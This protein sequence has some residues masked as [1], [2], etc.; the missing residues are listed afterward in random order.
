MHVLF[1]GHGFTEQKFTGCWRESLERGKREKE[2]R[3]EKER[4]RKREKKDKPGTEMKECFQFSQ[5]FRKKVRR[6]R[7]NTANV[8]LATFHASVPLS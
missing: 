2:K 3:K 7:S 1:M 6:G 5:T 8:T 4:E